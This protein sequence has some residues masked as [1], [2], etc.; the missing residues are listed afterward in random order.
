[1]TV[2]WNVWLPGPQG[3]GELLG[4]KHGHFNYRRK[5]DASQV[6]KGIAGARLLRNIKVRQARRFYEAA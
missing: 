3:Y 6:A 2:Y 1:M 4:D 5:S